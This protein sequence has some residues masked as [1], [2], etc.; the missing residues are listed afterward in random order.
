LGESDP[1]PRAT[2]AAEFL[3]TPLIAPSYRT[4]P[5]RV[6]AA[7]LREETYGGIAQCPVDRF[8]EF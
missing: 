1:P 3:R 5:T 8:E 6:A 4:V 7:P 2:R